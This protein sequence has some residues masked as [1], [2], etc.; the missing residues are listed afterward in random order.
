VYALPN[1]IRV[2]KSRMKWAGHVAH[3]KLWLE[4]CKG[5]DHL[6]NLAIDGRIMLKWI[7]EK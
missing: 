2:I 3:I 7:S 5:R 4:K 6:E 1:I